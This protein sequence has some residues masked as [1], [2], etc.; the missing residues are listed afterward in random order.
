[1]TGL[2]AVFKP[3]CLVLLLGDCSVVQGALSL[4][5]TRL[6]F[7]GHYP[8]ASIQADNIGAQPVLLQAWLSTEGGDGTPA[9]DLPFVITPHLAQLQ[10]GARQTLRV[11]YQGVGMPAD[12]E[13]LLYLYVMGI[14][15]RSDAAQQLSIAIRQRINLFYRPRGL[16]GDPGEAAQRLSWQRTDQSL[17][18]NNPTP[19]HVSLLHLTLEGVEL[20]DYL[21]IKPHSTSSVPVVVPGSNAPGQRLAFNA[22][23][24][25]GGQ[26]AYCSEVP[27]A[28]AFNVRLIQPDSDSII[29]KC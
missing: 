2:S 14:P 19:F 17:Q 24:D 9:A 3:L 26:R 12:R 8:E 5:G 16:P 11:L 25:Y 10:A 13:S 23:T 20:A 4:S 18:V 21:L 29:R 1:M 22:L 6:V 28:Q 7:D 15:R 27:R